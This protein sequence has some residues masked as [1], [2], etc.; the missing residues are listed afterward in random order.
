[1]AMGSLFFVFKIGGLW[2]GKIVLCPVSLLLHHLSNSTPVR[3]SE[4]HSHHHSNQTFWIFASVLYNLLSQ[5]S[6]HRTPG[7]HGCFLRAVR[8]LVFLFLQV[9]VW[10]QDSVGGKSWMEDVSPPSYHPKF[11]AY[12][13]FGFLWCFLSRMQVKK[14]T[15]QS[16][17]IT[18][19]QNTAWPTD[20]ASFCISLFLTTIHSFT[21]SLSLRSSEF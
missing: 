1:M 3:P 12:F 6:S 19:S 7:V 17:S 4:S 11:L 14:G 15:F 9:T 21:L 20:K 18:A 8:W 16:L 10:I 5:L 2:S 13:I